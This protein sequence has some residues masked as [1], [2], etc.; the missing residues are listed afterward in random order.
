M[1]NPYDDPYGQQAPRFEPP[2]EQYASQAPVP[3]QK[4]SEGPQSH[5]Q[6]PFS[7]EG[8]IL[9]TIY[10]VGTIAFPLITLYKV[11]TPSDHG[12]SVIAGLLYF[13]VMSYGYLNMWRLYRHVR[14]TRLMAWTMFGLSLPLASFASSP[15][16]ASLAN[17]FFLVMLVLSY[18]SAGA[19]IANNLNGKKA[20]KPQVKK[21]K[22]APKVTPSVLGDAMSA[23]QVAPNSAF[24]NL[25]PRRSK[26]DWTFKIKDADPTHFELMVPRYIGKGT[27]FGVAGSHIGSNVAFEEKNTTAGV[28]GEERVGAMLEELVAKHGGTVVHGLRFRPGKDGSDVDHVVIF[29]NKVCLVDAKMWAYGEYTW[30]YDGLFRDGKPFSGGDVH[31]ADAIDMWSDYLGQPVNSIIV[32]ANKDASRYKVDQNAHPDG[33][34]LYSLDGA[35]AFLESTVFSGVDVNRPSLVREVTKQMQ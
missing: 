14:N 5:F 32:M 4:P 26:K 3:P 1:S 12:A 8:D 24:Q 17:I 34:S 29:N 18:T 23:R 2:S 19:R 27:V 31:M 15:G 33:L 25:G 10:K 9:T 6:S 28:A 11:F 22:T 13:V 35:R 30:Q 21:P 20:P 16:W 7:G